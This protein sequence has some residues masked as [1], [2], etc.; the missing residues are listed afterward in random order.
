MSQTDSFIEEVTEEVRRDRLFTLMRK[1]GWLAILCVLLLVGGAAFNEW[2]KAKN[3]ASAQAFGD[4]L[5]ASI[6]DSDGGAV[7]A[8]N[9]ETDGPG[10]A[11]M[12]ANVAAALAL[13]TGETEFALR[14]LERIQTI[15][16]VEPIYR[17]LASFKRALALPGSDPSRKEAFE[18]LT[19]PGGPFRLLAQEQ[20]A[21]L[22]IDNG[23]ID[24]AIARLQELLASAGVT[25]GLQQRAAELIVALGGSLDG[26]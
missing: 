2:R 24:A 6:V 3:A 11:A 21:L 9:I 8:S 18:A 17:D 5:L 23:E 12:A 4:A 10:Q 15:P 26:A 22:E 13:E 25:P 14:Q 7:D 16:D 20:L 1:W 19:L